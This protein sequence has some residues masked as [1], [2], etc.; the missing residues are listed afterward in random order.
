MKNVADV[1]QTV[2][3]LTGGIMEASNLYGEVFLLT[4]R[5]QKHAPRSAKTLRRCYYDVYDI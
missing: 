5:Q 2:A 1:E 4:S 3:S